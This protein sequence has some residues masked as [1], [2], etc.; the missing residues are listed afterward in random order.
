MRVPQWRADRFR[1][2]SKLV[3]RTMQW[4]L[5][6]RHEIGTDLRK[7]FICKNTLT[8]LEVHC[9]RFQGLHMHQQSHSLDGGTLVL[10]LQWYH[11]RIL[12][13]SSM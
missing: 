3:L 2:L 5:N 13:M 12:N 10:F 4:P 11:T 8:L 6:L 1:R 7:S 9:P